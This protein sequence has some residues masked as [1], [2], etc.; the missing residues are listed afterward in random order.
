MHVRAQNN[1]KDAV[2]PHAGSLPPVVSIE[3]A[4]AVMDVSMLEPLL[5]LYSA[6]LGAMD[7]YFDIASKAF[8]ALPAP[9]LTIP[10]RWS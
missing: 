6:V 10:P 9:N 1:D 4:A 3:S 8:D 2:R 7:G 5:E